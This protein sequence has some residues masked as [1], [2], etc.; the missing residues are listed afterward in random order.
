MPNALVV[1]NWKMWGSREQAKTLAS[2]VAGSSQSG[3]EW[4]VCPPFPYLQIAIDQLGCD[5]VGAQT[6]SADQAVPH[7]GDVSAEM[8]ADLGVRWV[9]VGH[10][11]RRA[12]RH[13]T[14][15]LVRAQVER[16]LSQGLVP[17][18]CV[19]ETLEQRNAG[20]AESVVIEQLDAA[21]QGLAPT[22]DLVVAYEP[23]WAI[24]TGVV[25]T[26]EQAQA[27]HALVRQRVKD[28]GLSD[29]TPLL[30]GGSVKPDNAE[31]LFA[32]ADVDGALVG[33]ASLDA[34]AFLAIID[35]AAAAKA[36]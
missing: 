19:G 15:A 26:P 30:Y 23:V 9:I 12:E 13:E 16:A 27:M 17:I 28:L 3:V 11:E 7:T 10:S 5:R 36:E 18:V 25:A 4:G 6:V 22:T 21:L 32:L 34:Q 20:Q 29:R 2:N 31:G 24:G 8:L 1:G 33:G 14:N 35:A